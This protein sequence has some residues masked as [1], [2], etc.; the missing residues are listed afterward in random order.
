[1]LETFTP[2]EVFCSYA[3]EDEALLRKVEKHLSLLKQQGLISLWHNRLI[4]PGSDWAATIG[5]HLE[6]ASV[7][8]L[9]ISADFLSSDYCYSIEMQRAL[10]RHQNKQARVIPVLL[11]PVDWE[12]SPC[13]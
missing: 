13:T 12:E 5:T 10:Q 11:R 9:F 6:T 8:L 1:M 4:S 7:I 3:H 2:T